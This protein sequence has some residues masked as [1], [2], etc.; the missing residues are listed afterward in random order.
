MKSVVILGGGNA[1]AMFANRMRKGFSKN[2]L[3]TTMIEKHD[4][5]FWTLPKSNYLHSI[6]KVA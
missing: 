5:H 2:G 4:T 6:V 3:N 1:G